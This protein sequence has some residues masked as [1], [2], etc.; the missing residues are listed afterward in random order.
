MADTLTKDQR[1]YV[2]SRIRSKW[3]KQEVVMH[4]YLKG[5]KIRHKMHPKLRGSPDLILT[6]YKVAIFLHGCFWHGC[7]WHYREPK[8]NI[9]YWRSK[10]KSNILRDRKNVKALKDKG[11]RVIVRWEHE[12]KNGNFGRKQNGLHGI[13][14]NKK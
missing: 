4:N 2:M 5:H 7:K 10:I 9:G 14:T 1:S 12:I 6:D 13:Y 11:Y 3:T 8:T